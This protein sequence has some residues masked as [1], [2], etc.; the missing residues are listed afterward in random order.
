MPAY[1]IEFTTERGPQRVQFTLD[2]HRPLAQQVAQV[3]E[4]LRLQQVIILGGHADRLAVYWRGDEM[5]T[6]RTISQLGINPNAAIEF[7]MVGPRRERP[8]P[9]PRGFFPRGAF[10][11]ALLGAGGGAL[12]WWTGGWW[13]DLGPIVN[14]YDRLDL[15]TVVALGTLVGGLVSLGAALRERRSAAGWLLAGLGLGALG[16]AFGAAL[17]IVVSRRI[18]VPSLG[19]FVALRAAGW[20]VAAAAIAAAIGLLW[21]GRDPRRIGEGAVLGGIAGAAG[22]LLVY[23]PGAVEAWHLAGM[24][25]AGAG[26]GLGLVWPALRRAVAVVELVDVGGRRVGLTNLREWGLRHGDTVPL[27]PRMGVVCTAGGC[28]A[29]PHGRVA[30]SIGGHEVRGTVDLRNEDMIEIDGLA[31]R[32]RRVPGVAV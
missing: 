8:E 25:L 9:P 29:I 6:G 30:A 32:Y 15:V 14:R 26:I 5:D 27:S 22:G 2:E 10:A 1:F 3:L 28:R 13:T 12:A 21:F 31:Y 11:S 4:E 20:A 19:T 24:A 16:G 18:L 7:R 17:L 23:L